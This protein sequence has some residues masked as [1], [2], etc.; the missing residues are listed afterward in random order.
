MKKIIG[1]IGASS[2][3][4][5]E[6]KIAQ[7]VGEEIA[8]TGGILI[9]GG[10]GGVMEAACR[11]AK[12]YQGLT[13]GILPGTNKNEANNYVDV[14][15]LTGL[16]EARNIIIIRTSEVVIAV[17]GE[18]GTLSEIAFALKLKVPVIGINTYRLFKEDKEQNK[19]IRAKEAKDAV[20]KALQLI[21][22]KRNDFIA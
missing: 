17:G 15:I 20:Q 2:C 19:I 5:E 3:S 13:I 22:C 10:L 4:K 1:V 21:K 12:K 7:E 16:S 8:K 6:E 9:C 14:P 11:G 18:Y